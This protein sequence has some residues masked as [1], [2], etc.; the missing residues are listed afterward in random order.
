MKR[1]TF[2]LGVAL[3]LLAGWPGGARAG[4][5]NGGFETGDLTGWGA[6]PGRVSVQSSVFKPGSEPGSYGPVEGSHF[7]YLSADGG[8]HSATLSQSI[9]AAAGDVLRFSVF[10]KDAFPLSGDNG[11]AF[12]HGP[13]DF[14]VDVPLI[15]LAVTP[16]FKETENGVIEYP[17]STPWTEVSY[18]F[19][20]P[21]DYTLVFDLRNDHGPLDGSALGVDNVRLAQVP[22]PSAA[23][24]A[25]I[26]AC[27][28]WG[29][30]CLRRRPAAG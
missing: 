7:A 10:F 15:R 20:T 9:T 25:G 5:V 6:T 8:A 16:S 19:T 3:L 2:G 27:V 29:G 21:G 18:V 4:L 14:P 26:G 22:A 23:V 30:R 24:L 28:L 1:I 17:G 12:L 13:V 11:Y